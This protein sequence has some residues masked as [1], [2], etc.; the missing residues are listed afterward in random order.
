MAEVKS[1]DEL[2]PG[3]VFLTEDWNGN[4][5]KLTVEEKTD[6]GLVIP[7]ELGGIDISLDEFYVVGKKQNQ[8]KI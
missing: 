2:Q 3:D 6:C 4:P 8:K 5:I 7:E 1:F